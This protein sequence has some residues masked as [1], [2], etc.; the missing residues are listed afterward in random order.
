[1]SSFGSPTE[2]PPMAMPSKPISSS[3]ASDSSRRS[4]YMPPC[5]MP[6][7]ALA[8]PSRACSSRERC[9]QR[10]E[11]RIDSAASARVAG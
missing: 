9:A 5:T 3:P 11:R 4:S 2:R 1:M 7:S 8:L 6:N 10:S